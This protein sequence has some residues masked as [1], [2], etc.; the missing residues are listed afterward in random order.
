MGMRKESVAEPQSHTDVYEDNR[1]AHD[2]ASLRLFSN[3]RGCF[4]FFSKTSIMCLS[5]M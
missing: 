5:S 4:L 1:E 3:R 2:K